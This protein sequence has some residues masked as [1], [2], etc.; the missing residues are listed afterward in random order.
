[1]ALRIHTL[2]FWVTTLH[3]LLVAYKTSA[4]TPYSISECDY[5]LNVEA[6]WSS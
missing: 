2:V 3:S 5:T 6:V 1:M 4:D